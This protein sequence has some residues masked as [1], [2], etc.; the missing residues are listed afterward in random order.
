MTRALAL[1]LLCAACGAPAV[2]ADAQEC[3]A[4]APGSTY[5]GNQGWS[6]TIVTTDPAPPARF[7]NRWTVTIADPDGRPMID[8]AALAVSAF[9]P[10]HGHGSPTTPVVTADADGLDVGPLELWM[11]G[12][13][14]V[15][16][17]LDGERIVVQVCIDE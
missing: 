2:D 8:P 13:W 1:L 11:P 3:A 12:R 5:A 16:F 15:R 14:E 9:M 6:L 17:D 4:V 7:T 10:E